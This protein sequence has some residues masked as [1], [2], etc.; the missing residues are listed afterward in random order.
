MA[1]ENDTKS[2]FAFWA[3]PSGKLNYWPQSERES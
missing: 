1:K 2:E 3:R